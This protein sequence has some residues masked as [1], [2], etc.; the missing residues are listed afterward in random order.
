MTPM[1]IIKDLIASI[2]N[3]TIING[4]NLTINPGEVHVIM[5]PNGSGKSTLA[6]V[7]ARH[8]DYKIESGSILFNGKDILE[9]TPEQCAWDGLFLSFQYPVAIPGV[10]NIQFIK[11]AVNAV[12]KY[13]NKPT[14]DAVEFLQLVKEK[15]AIL[16]IDQDFMYR[17]INE[18][19]SGGEK[20]RNEILQMILLEPKLAI[21]DE[22]DSGLDIDALKDVANGV[23]AQRAP[24]RSILMITHY[25]RLLDYITPDFV[26]V[27]TDGKLIYSG[28]KT[29]PAE[30]EAKGYA[31]V[32]D[33]AKQ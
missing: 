33:K 6:N 15:M 11:S 29:L 28:D 13:Q 21:L 24:N 30:L 17:S 5:G 32:Q 27:M 19:F 22:T 18:G 14:Y 16:N 8:K 1:L 2:D 23:N 9:A 25:Q 7:L 3:K 12:R 10:T 4:L 31:W 20:K 26:H